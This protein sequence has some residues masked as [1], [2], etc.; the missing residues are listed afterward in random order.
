MEHYL[1]E[2]FH[3]KVK[4]EKMNTT[5]ILSSD[6]DGIVLYKLYI[7][8][9]PFV[10]AYIT[11]DFTFEFINELKS[12]IKTLYKLETVFFFKFM[13]YRKEQMFLES[14]TYFVVENRFVYMPFLG[15]IFKEYSHENM[16][17]SFYKKS[18]EKM[19]LNEQNKFGL[20][21]LRP[22]YVLSYAFLLGRGSYP[23]K[24]LAE[25]LNIPV[26]TM[27]AY[28]DQYDKFNFNITKYEGG[29][30][31][32]DL[33]QLDEKAIFNIL[34]NFQNPVKNQFFHTAKSNE[35]A[36]SSYSIFNL[37]N[38]LNFNYSKYDIRGIYNDVKEKRIESLFNSEK[39]T[40]INKKE[41]SNIGKQIIQEYAVKSYV[42]YNNIKL[43]NPFLVIASFKPKELE[44]LEIKQ[45]I[46]KLIKEIF[47]RQIELRIVNN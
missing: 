17:Y 8:P 29:R 12:K 11:R 31:F 42:T 26:C 1:E 37:F 16:M 7:G 24:L 44:N 2:I 34:V 6:I 35:L 9:I 22:S 40:E 4:S 23:L 18:E 47:D 28:F 32:L 38:N 15:L 43:I 30:R 46:L 36:Y 39:I 10:A 45:A 41:Y 20:L 13:H 25:D 27:K 33:T 19:I 5:N 21:P 3:L 14:N